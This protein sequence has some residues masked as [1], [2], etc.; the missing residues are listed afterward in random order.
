MKNIVKFLLCLV[1][2]LT[3][4][5]AFAID[6]T[7]CS[8]T[9]SIESVKA[10]HIL[11][12]TK[13]EAYSIKAMLDKGAKFED[14]AKKY[15]K[16]PSGQS[17]GDLGFFGRGEMVPEFEKAAFELPIGKVSEPIQTPFGWHLIKVIDKE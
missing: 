15:S 14:L 10:N 8:C 17:G 9:V 7:P 2:C 1:C 4:N 12:K 3:V 13:Q 11:V 16:C 5:S 6:P